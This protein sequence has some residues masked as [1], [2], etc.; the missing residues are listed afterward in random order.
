MLQLLERVSTTHIQEKK[1]T[2]I[3]TT[4]HVYTHIQESKLA[5]YTTTIKHH[6]HTSKKVSFPQLDFQTFRLTI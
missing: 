5:P 3:N 1:S 4:Q 2:I 6:T